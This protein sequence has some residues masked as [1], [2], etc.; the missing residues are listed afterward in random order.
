M[1]DATGGAGFACADL[2]TFCRLDELGL[3]VTGQRLDCDRAMLACRI[4]DEDRW[5]RRCGEQGSPHDTGTRQLAHEPFGWRPTTLLV[6]I[7][8]YGCASCR[9]VWR[10]NTSSAA[11]PR[12]KLSR[13]G[14][15]WALE[16]IV[17]QHLTI[18]R[19]AEGLAVSWNTANDAVLAEGKRRLIDDPGRFDGV[20]VIGVDEHVWRHTRRGDK[21]VT[22]IIDLTGIREAPARRGC[23][24]WSRAAQNRP[25]WPGWPNETSPGARR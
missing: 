3:E 10:Q 23:W 13:R 7:R 6:T 21:Y 19:V 9:H 18:A 22:V 17:C 5:C 8:R 24:T 16:A 20:K 11:E 25:S 15:R 1:H 12:A 14:L 2:T 4:T